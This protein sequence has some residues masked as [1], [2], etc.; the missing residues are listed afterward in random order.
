MTASRGADATTLVAATV[1][2]APAL[3]QPRPHDE[4]YSCDDP[5]ERS[6]AYAAADA[7]GTEGLLRCW[8][9]ET[10]LGPPEDGTLYVPLPAAG[11]ALRVPVR[12]WSPVGHHRFGAAVLES[13]G[14]PAD[15]V[16]VA[17]LLALEAAASAT[18]TPGTAYGPVEAAHP[19]PDGPDLVARV[20]DSVRR[21]AAFIA[22]RRARPEAPPHTHPFLDAE[23]SLLLG[24]PLHPTPKSREG[25]SDAEAGAYSPELRGAFPLHWLAVERS[26]LAMDS[27]WTERGRPVPADQLLARLAG[28]VP[29]LP[30][31]YV[32]LPL[33]P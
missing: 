24:H 19:G 32:A 21:T 10:A 23:Q 14:R 5:L 15:A 3:P 8:V 20:A 31:G 17:A 9:R 25:L 1:T 7:A 16:T 27:A 33:H 26:V 18:T 12:H 30:D 13:S 29:D 4:P 11:T 22:D 6:N 2:V 28:P